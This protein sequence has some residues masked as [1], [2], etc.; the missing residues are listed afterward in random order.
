MIFFLGIIFLVSI[1]FFVDW[2]S[3]KNKKE[4]NKKI[5]LIIIF[6]SILIGIILLIGG[7]YLY[8]PLFFSIAAWFLRKKIIFDV[9]LNIFR[10]KQ[11]SNQND[12]NQKMSLNESYKLLGIDENASKEVIIKSHKELIRKLH[13]DKGGSS[14]LSAKVNE[15]RDIIL[16]D[17]EKREQN[18]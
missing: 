6:L 17:K 8:S 7:L 15:A 9:L 4:L 2:L 3:A 12:Y 1:L 18:G 10:K 5:N 11:K 16:A 14:Y 13:P